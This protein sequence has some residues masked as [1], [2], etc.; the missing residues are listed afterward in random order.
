MLLNIARH[1]MIKLWM[2]YRNINQFTF[3]AFPLLSVMVSF[4]LTFSCVELY[5]MA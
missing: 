1:L 5:R 4:V 3:Y 2:L